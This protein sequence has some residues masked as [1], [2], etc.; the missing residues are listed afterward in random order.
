MDKSPTHCVD[1]C[2]PIDLFLH[3][4]NSDLDNVV[5]CISKLHDEHVEIKILTDIKNSNRFLMENLLPFAKIRHFDNLNVEFFIVDSS[6]IYF[7]LSGE[8]IEKEQVEGDTNHKKFFLNGDKSVISQQ[9]RMFNLMWNLGVDFKK[10]T[11]QEKKKG[12][13]LKNKEIASITDSFSLMELLKNLKKPLQSDI[14][15]YSPTIQI[16]ERFLSVNLIAFLKDFSDLNKVKTRVLIPEDGILT[17]SKKLEYMML[18]LDNL[19]RSSSNEST[20]MIRSLPSSNH[21]TNDPEYFMLLIDNIHLIII[22]TSSSN[23]LSDSVVKIE[24]NL[25]CKQYLNIDTITVYRNIFNLLWDKALLFEKISLQ[26]VMQ[27][28]LI[29]SIAHE[30]RTP[31]QAILGYSEMAL[32]DYQVNDPSSKYYKQ[33]FDLI[34]RNAN[35]L[36]SIVLNILNVAKIDNTTFNLDRQKNNLVD[37]IK[38]AIND[39]SFILKTE[40]FHKD[41]A[42]DFEITRDS[43]KI[44]YSNVDSIRIYEVLTNIFTNSVQFMKSSGKISISISFLTKTQ[45]EFIS[46]FRANYVIDTPDHNNPPDVKDLVMIQISDDG[47]GINSQILARVFNKFVST[48]D[49]HIG[50]GLYISRY[51][52]ESHDGWIWASNNMHGPGSTFHIVLP[53]VSPLLANKK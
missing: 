48:V 52:I 53:L 40:D 10:N 1:I 9:T 13:A 8:S 44:A 28:N 22:D 42:I 37:I 38:Q 25:F 21:M 27:K 46:G 4:Q 15:I 24:K 23:I 51:I 32:V 6:S 49:N 3:W 16:S 30:L 45:L 50:L 11:L 35:R 36:S 33:Y 14:L 18:E 31:T 26:D 20:L 43:E 19:W 47:I 29:D 7:P 5:N 2:G 17:R 12:C 39:Y 34:S 41:K